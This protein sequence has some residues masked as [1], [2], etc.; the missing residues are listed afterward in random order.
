MVLIRAAN[1]YWSHKTSYLRFACGRKTNS[2][3]KNSGALTLHIIKMLEGSSVL[4]IYFYLE[5]K[6][7]ESPWLAFLSVSHSA[8]PSVSECF[9]V[10]KLCSS[11]GDRSHSIWDYKDLLDHPVWP[12]RDSLKIENTAIGLCQQVKKKKLAKKD[13]FHAVLV[14][15]LSNSALVTSQVG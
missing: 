2:L 11:L 14:F 10:N 13:F 4:L 9:Y 8:F 12:T 6:P 3:S 7:L 5:R 1:V 15:N